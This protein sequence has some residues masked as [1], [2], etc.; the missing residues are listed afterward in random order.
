[1][2]QVAVAVHILSAVVWLGGMLFLVM[3]MLPIARQAMRAG[4]PGPGL[5]MLRAA[6]QRFLLVAWAAMI[7]LGLSGIYLA[8]DHWGIRPGV[9]FS[10]GGRFLNILQAKTILFAVVVLLSLMHDFWLGPKILERLDRARTSGQVLPQSL[11]RVI[12]R[13]TASVNLVM[14]V[15]IL[16]LAVWLIRP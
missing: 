6:A 15:T 9:F 2:Y 11:G 14:A 5:E 3:V 4:G 1:M 8:W 7:L 12:V 10:E 13:M 16:L